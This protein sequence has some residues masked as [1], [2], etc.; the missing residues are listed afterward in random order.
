MFG[1]VIIPLDGSDESLLALG[2]AGVLARFL[3]STAVV[4]GFD[5][6]TSGHDF[7]TQLEQQ[8]G[9][10]GDVPRELVIRPLATGVAP[11]LLAL[12]A[13]RPGSLLCIPTKDRQTDDGAHDQ[14]VP[15]ILRHATAPV[16]LVGPAV[17]DHRFRGHGPL[18]TCVDDTDHSRAILPVVEAFG[19]VFPYDVEV[20]HVGTAERAEATASEIAGVLNRQVGARGLAGDGADSQAVAAA[21]SA[22]ADDSR[23]ALI[24]M[25]THAMP[26]DTDAAL[27]SVTAGVVAQAACPVLVM[28]PLTPR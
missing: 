17:Q 9:A 11:S 21:I 2:P 20:V 25:A 3:D 12:L 14:V 1:D 10:L 24:A 23:A 27:D 7:A 22:A 5:D 26:A 18:L 15:E 4:V 19:I 16:L 13:E 8:L 28:R 6:G